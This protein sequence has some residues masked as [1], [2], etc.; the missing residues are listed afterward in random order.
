MKTKTI[1]VSLM[2]TFTTGALF[3]QSTDTIPKKTDTTKKDT[4]ALLNNIRANSLLKTISKDNAEIMHEQ[5]V[6]ALPAKT[7]RISQ[8]KKVATSGR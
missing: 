6:Y 4:T 3:A 1:A 8:L 5:T 7:A 2:L